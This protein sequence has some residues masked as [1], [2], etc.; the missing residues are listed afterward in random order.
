MVISLRQ[1]AVAVVVW[2]LLHMTGLMWLLDPIVRS[3]HRQHREFASTNQ[4]SLIAS[5]SGRRPGHWNGCF[6]H[7]PTHGVLPTDGYI[8]SFEF[9]SLSNRL[10]S[11]SGLFANI[12]SRSFDVPTF[13]GRSVDTCHEFATHWYGDLLS[14]TNPSVSS[15]ISPVGVVFCSNVT[16]ATAKDRLPHKLYLS[17]HQRTS[18]AA[19]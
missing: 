19:G 1:E 8:P 12:L 17:H 9:V 10:S 18:E 5:G 3:H 7:R 11:Q 15:Y 13:F 14:T 6:A 16:I 4:R 2:L